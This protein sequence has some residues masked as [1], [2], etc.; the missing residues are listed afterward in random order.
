MIK[1]RCHAGG[2][3][4]AHNF[5]CAWL[6]AFGARGLSS[7]IQAHL[8]AKKGAQRGAALLIVLVFVALLGITLASIAVYDAYRAREREARVAGHEIYEIAKAARLYVRDEFKADP[9][10]TT[11]AA[12]PSLISLADLKAGG[13]LPN[14]F[15]RFSGADALSALNQ[16]IFVI[17]TNW[18]LG[19]PTANSVPTAFV[20]FKNG[21]RGRATYMLT[22]STVDVLREMNANISA[23]VFNTAGVLQSS[24]CQG[25]GP[26][27]SRWDTG[28]LTTAQFNT[29]VG[30]LPAA[31]RSFTAGSL[32]VPAWKVAQP[33][34]RA[35]MRYAQPEHSDH[36]TMLTDIRMGTCGAG[37]VV[38]NTTDASGNRV[39][40]T[41]DLCNML[42]DG[43]RSPTDNDR[44][45]IVDVGNMGAQRLI[46]EPQAT[47]LEPDNTAEPIYEYA[48]SVSGNMDLQGDLRIFNDI[49]L[50]N[51]VQN[52]A[53]PDSHKLTHRMNIQDGTLVTERN[54]YVFSTNAATAGEANIGHVERS[55]RLVS[56]TLETPNFI[57]MDE[58]L[59]TALPAGAAMI[60]V[61][62][63]MTLENMNVRG[64][65]NP[66]SGELIADTIRAQPGGGQVGATLN[67]LDIAP[68]GHVQVSGEIN[69]R[70]GPINV[71]VTDDARL[72]SGQHIGL[73]AE[74]ADGQN[75]TV[76]DHFRGLEA[77]T[78]IMTDSTRDYGGANPL[79]NIHVTS[80]PGSPPSLT[81]SANCRESNT[82]ANAC[83]NRQYVPQ[84][85]T[86]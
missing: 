57:S 78:M 81:G 47:D 46:V 10:L 8:G 60:N 39:P 7:G 15:G 23:P 70:G 14:N 71:H 24:D 38:I 30:I 29:L 2:N 22:R 85:I 34:P 54:M 75:M 26:A 31:Q 44:F 84:G 62:D 73:F 72:I 43:V 12:T 63:R 51:A 6:L 32:V 9:N 36:A 1:V 5:G 59:H 86:P 27:I 35:V 82:V 53:R 67:T 18:P 79:K 11:V 74:I 16:H 77:T 69:T 45:N 52:A 21:T 56:G 4:H 19:A 3:R 76:T 61:T 50:P 40:S 37:H 20:F 66:S 49:A 80:G 41:T 68:V 65:A 58:S 13:Y 48:L 33:D 42:G 28:C 17:R 64:I 55:R 25:G 83:P